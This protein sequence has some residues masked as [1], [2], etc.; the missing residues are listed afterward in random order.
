MTDFLK[1]D[2]GTLAGIRTERSFSG[3]V[4]DT[5]SKEGCVMWDYINAN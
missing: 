3:C 4:T 1:Y 5:D 2:N